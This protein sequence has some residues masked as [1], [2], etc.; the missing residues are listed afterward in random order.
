MRWEDVVR[1]HADRARDAQSLADMEKAVLMGA[2]QEA[3]AA[4]VSEYVIADAAGVARSTVRHW[5]GK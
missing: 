2:A 4:G 3:H 1:L 5:L